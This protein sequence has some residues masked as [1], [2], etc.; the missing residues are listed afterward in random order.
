[1]LFNTTHKSSQMV[2]FSVP[3]LYNLTQEEFDWPQYTTNQSAPV[4]I[5]RFSLDPDTQVV[6]L[7]SEW[8]PRADFWLA[9]D[10]LLQFPPET[11]TT[12]MM[13][14]TEIEQN[15]GELKSDSKTNILKLE[16]SEVR[17]RNNYIKTSQQH[18]NMR[19]YSPV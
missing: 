4:A 16:G 7:R 13:T 5:A 11:T 15:P 19:M 1:M 18:D 6:D 14:S 10:N 12:E 9:I 2:F 8:Q 3:K 17:N